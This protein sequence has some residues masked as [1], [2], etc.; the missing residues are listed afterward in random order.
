[1]LLSG[2]KSLVPFPPGCDGFVVYAAG[3]SGWER[4]LVPADAPGLEISDP[5]LT[6]GLSALKLA[7]L[8][9]ENVNVDPGLLLPPRN[10]STFLRRLM[11]GLA[12]IAVGNARAALSESAAYARERYQG[13]TKI[14]NQPAIQV[15]LGE[16]WSRAASC[17]AALKT[18]CAQDG[19][20]AEALL[21]A[22]SL[23]LRAGMDCWQAV[24]DC[25]QVLGGYGYMEDYRLEKR[26]RDAM[27]LKVMAIR[28]DDLRIFCGARLS[29]GD[30]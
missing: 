20:S 23:K 9:F 7:D 14:I 3:K 8:K 30:Q 18:V 15:L 29:G 13:G 24:T 21:R 11:L 6:V 22:I 25:L 28:P 16:A 19:E 2:C 27:H 26:L 17:G 1:L 4:V 10:P 12:A 5:G